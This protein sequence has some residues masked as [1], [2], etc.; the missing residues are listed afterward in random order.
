MNLFDLFIEELYINVM[1]TVV[2]QM[3]F[4]KVFNKLKTHFV[5]IVIIFFQQIF[6]QEHEQKTNINTLK[7]TLGKC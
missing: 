4:I 6:F 1:F 2:F 7:Q 3:L 5:W